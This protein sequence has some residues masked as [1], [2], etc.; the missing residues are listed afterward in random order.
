ML[1]DDSELLVDKVDGLIFDREIP[2]DIRCEVFSFF[3]GHAIGFED[4]QP[5][6]SGKKQGGTRIED[7]DDDDDDEARTALSV[8]ITKQRMLCN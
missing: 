8:T 3:R 5:A 6:Y 7:L 2:L 1:T 4:V